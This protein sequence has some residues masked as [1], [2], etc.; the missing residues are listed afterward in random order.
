MIARIAF[1]LSSRRP[2]LTGNEE[3]APR[4]RVCCDNRQVWKLLKLR[5]KMAG[6]LP[7]FLDSYLA[8][9]SLVD[10]NTTHFILKCKQCFGNKSPLSQVKY[11]T[12]QQCSCRKVVQLCWPYP[13]EE[14]VKADRWQLW[15]ESAYKIQ[16]SYRFLGK[17]CFCFV[18]KC[19]VFSPCFC[20]CKDQLNEQSLDV[21]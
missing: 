5:V 13:D 15:S 21:G 1:I 6:P 14:Q 12:P 16:Q 3:N 20:V 8:F 4:M 11:D 19:S 17:M 7:G 10:N 9:F 2:K 18:N